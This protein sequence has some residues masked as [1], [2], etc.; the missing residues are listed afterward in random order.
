MPSAEASTSPAHRPGHGF[1]LIP[2]RGRRPPDQGT[3]SA[4]MKPDAE[5]FPRYPCQPDFLQ[6]DFRLRLG[7]Q[8]RDK[9]GRP[10]R[11]AIRWRYRPS[12]PRGV[13]PRTATVP[14]HPPAF[15]LVGPRP[16]NG[17]RANNFNESFSDAIFRAVTPSGSGS[18]L[19]RHAKSFRITARARAHLRG[20]KAPKVQPAPVQPADIPV[21]PA[22]PCAGSADRL[23]PP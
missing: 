8:A 10:Q 21:V 1:D 22:I 6:G 15:L 20:S 2:T 9:P 14:E 7:Q 4:G 16:S 13:R 5:C 17:S 19:R 11:S 18:G 12:Q 23:F 3:A